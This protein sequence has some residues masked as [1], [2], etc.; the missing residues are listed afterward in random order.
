MENTKVYIVLNQL[1]VYELNRLQK[2]ILSPYF[3]ANES[4]TDLFQVLLDSLKKK[5][6]TP[7]GKHDVW[8][9]IFSKKAYNDVKFRKLQSDLLKL[10]EDFLAQEIY[11]KNPMHRSNYLLEAVSKKK[12]EKLYSTTIKYSERLA[13]QQFERPASYYFHLYVNEKN[14]FNLSSEFEKKTKSKTK[15]GDLK[16]TEINENLDIFYLAEKLRY[17]CSLL[18]WK[19]ITKQKEEILFIEDIIEYVKQQ[20]YSHIPP[21][22]IYYQ[23]YLTTIEPDNIDHYD[24]LKVLVH[25]HLE[26][27]PENQAREIFDSLLN[28][29]IRKINSG[30]LS[31]YEEMFNHYTYAID[32]ELLLVDGYLSPTSFRNICLIGLRTKRFEF[33]E[34]FILSKARLIEDK[35]RDNAV[36][37]NL[38]RL[39]WYQKEFEKVIAQI[40]SVDFNDLIYDLGS[41]TML[42]SSYFELDSYDSL[43]SLFDSF[44]VYLNRNKNI[45]EKLRKAYLE[46][47]KYTKKLSG[48]NFSKKDLESILDEIQNHPNLNSK[49]WLIE[50]VNELLI[51]AK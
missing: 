14:K 17:Y 28:Y 31:F 4:I 15:E 13:N 23:I 37:F 1:D 25:K 29:C 48:L 18:S 39:Y 32:N 5:N 41:K 8:E 30:K 11:E 16:L 22:T 24:K 49:P 34:K 35:Y 6:K 38:A 20:N 9:M 51:N 19:N 12:I 43:L 50:K 42:L 21:I 36:N 7:I 2:F 45:P 46:L 26:L 33:T 3:N 44:R 10:I 40:Q 27:F 47:I